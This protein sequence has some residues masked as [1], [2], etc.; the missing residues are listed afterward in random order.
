MKR[1]PEEINLFQV[2]RLILFSDAVFAIA[3]TLLIIEIKVPHFSAPVSDA[4]LAHEVV[5]QLPEWLGFLVSFTLVGVFWTLHHRVFQY[6]AN[7]DGRLIALNLLFLMTIVV[8][9]YSSAFFSAYPSRGLP[10]R[11]YCFNVA[12]S[13]ATMWLLWYHITHVRT[14]IASAIAAVRQYNFVRLSILTIG[15]AL[16][17]I[18]SLFLGLE[19]RICFILIPI[20][21]RVAK[22]RFGVSAEGV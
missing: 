1:N 3:I 10:F 13:G 2:E 8:M 7:Y 20:A 6:V 14:G 15:F 18:F 4:E 19:A 9:P 17:A 5:H 12:A 11:F 16:T 22:Q 21:M